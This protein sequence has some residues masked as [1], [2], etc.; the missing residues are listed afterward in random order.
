MALSILET[1]EPNSALAVWLFSQGR[2]V[3]GPHL[4]NLIADPAGTIS[5]I[6]DLIVWNGSQGQQLLAGLEGMGDQ[7]ERINQAVQ[8]IETA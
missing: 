5:R 1:F 3:L 7:V 4:Q 8:G 6:G 2:S